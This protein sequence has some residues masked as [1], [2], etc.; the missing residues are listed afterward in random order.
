M[1]VTLILR[2]PYSLSII[3]LSS[4]SSF[5]SNGWHGSLYGSSTR[6][7]G[8]KSKAYRGSGMWIRLNSPSW[9]RLVIVTSVRGHSGFVLSKTLDK[10]TM[11]IAERIGRKAKAMNGFFFNKG[12]SLAVLSL[13]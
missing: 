12:A 8:C 1:G 4:P 7:I 3:R 5:S 10:K 11:V 13:I 9:Y 6:K 2:K